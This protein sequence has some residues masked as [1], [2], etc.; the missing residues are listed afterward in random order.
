MK[1]KQQD[2]K[3]ILK[4]IKDADGKEYTVYI[5]EKK[6]NSQ[7]KVT[8][9][10]IENEEG[11]QVTTA[12]LLETKNKG[13][14]NARIMNVETKEQYRNQGFADTVLGFVEQEALI[15][16]YKKVD[17]IS[18]NQRSNLMYSK[19]DYKIVTGAMDRA[20]KFVKKITPANF[21]DRIKVRKLKR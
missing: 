5:K 11:K 14:K 2:E 7:A 21:I 17:L 4:K 13:R 9:I 12:S 16:G 10:T 8:T 3:R 6:L 1:P 20:S 18:V 15:K 19:R